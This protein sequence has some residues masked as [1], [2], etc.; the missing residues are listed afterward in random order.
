MQIIPFNQV[1]HSDQLTN[2]LTN[3]DILKGLGMNLM[4]AAELKRWINDEKII[5]ICIDLDSYVGMLNFYNHKTQRP[6]VEVGYLI[7][8]MFQGKGMATELLK[9][10]IQYLKDNYPEI[11]EI[12]ETYVEEFNVAS[13]RVLEKNGFEMYLYNSEKRRYYYRLKL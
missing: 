3:P 11:T 8:A 5:L 12:A 1:Q 10:G 7:D 4:S 13:K 2:W 6:Q 9:L